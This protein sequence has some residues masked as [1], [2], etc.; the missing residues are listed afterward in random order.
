MGKSK[1]MCVGCRDDF[2]NHR[3]KD[4]CWNFPSAT[5]MDRIRVG[6]WEN[7]PYSRDRAVECLSC[8]NPDG[9][10]MIKLSD[11]RVK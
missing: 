1:Q 4:G 9:S 7:P 11:P 6:I 5:V 2:Y 10:A 8:F 3:E